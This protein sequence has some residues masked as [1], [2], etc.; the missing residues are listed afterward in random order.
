MIYTLT[1]SPSLDYIN[2]ID[3]FEKNKINRSTI[4]KYIL[5]GKGINVSQVLK[6]LG[7]DSI[8]LGFKAGFTGDYLQKLFDE[9]NIKSD[10]IEV[11]GFTR[12]NVKVISNYETAI[13]SNTLTINNKHLQLLI[14][15]VKQVLADGDY[16]IISGSIPQN[17]SQDYY[18]NII[19]ELDS[20]INIV[21]DAEKDLLLNTLKYKPFLVK[22]NREELE[23][24]FNKKIKNLAEVIYYAKILQQQGAKNVI[25][26]LDADGALL[27]DQNNNEYYVKNI[28]GEKV[29]S[30][31]AGDSL[32]AGFIY[33]INKGLSFK[34]SLLL[35]VACGSATAFSEGLGNKSS[36]YQILELLKENN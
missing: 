8:V 5:G 11:E 29:N 23:Q 21:V 19:K 13:N 22:P 24:I 30:V 36:I 4:S 17:I 9:K 28:E 25:V 2:Y 7:E 26:S 35:G 12:I 15:K 3:D 18:E 33:G 34:E 14:S 1:V 10:L 31:G 20:N 16:L 27:I 6:I 32:I